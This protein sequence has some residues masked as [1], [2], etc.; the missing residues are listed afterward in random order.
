M[1]RHQPGPMDHQAGAQARGRS[2]PKAT[3][4]GLQPHLSLSLDATGAAVLTYTSGK[5]QSPGCARRGPRETQSL[6]TSRVLYAQTPQGT[7]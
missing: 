5:K 1:L 6:V 4:T 3:K 2:N 7:L